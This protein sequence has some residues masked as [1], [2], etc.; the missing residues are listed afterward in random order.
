VDSDVRAETLAEHLEK[1]QWAE[2]PATFGNTTPIA[3]E[4]L[5][6]KMS[7]ITEEELRDLFS[8]IG[9]IARKSHKW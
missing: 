5:P 1:V 6:V 7:D 9:I 4:N 8:G 3:K 2:R